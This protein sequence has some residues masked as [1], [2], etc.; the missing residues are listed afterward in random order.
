MPKASQK[1]VDG[2]TMRR[3]TDDRRR[4]GGKHLVEAI[5]DPVNQPLVRLPGAIE[6]FVLLSERLFKQP[7]RVDAG[8]FASSTSL[9][10]GMVA[11]S[12]SELLLDLN[13]RLST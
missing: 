11:K 6:E 10:A 8:N 2:S 7:T 13:G 4:V 1:G 12:F 5:E 9:I 3:N